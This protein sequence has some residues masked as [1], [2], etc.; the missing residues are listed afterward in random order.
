MV[1]RADHRHAR[2][3]DDALHAHR[4][5]D[6]LDHDNL[7]PGPR[8][9]TVNSNASARWYS[10]EE[11]T[12]I[13]SSMPAERMASVTPKLRSRL[14]A[15]RLESATKVPA[16]HIRRTRPSLSSARSASR[17]VALDTPSSLASVGSEGRRVPALS[18]PR[19]IR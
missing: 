8:R 14:L 9:S 13:P 18:W 19:S 15:T 7:L 17:R 4:F 12:A 5:A 1:Q 11:S 10:Y 3:V 2:V 16:P 6:T